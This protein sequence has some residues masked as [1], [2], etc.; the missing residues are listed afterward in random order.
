MSDIS[1][2][3]RP[4]LQVIRIRGLF[5]SRLQKERKENKIF[6]DDSKKENSKAYL[7]FVK[8]W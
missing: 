7:A 4:I 1:I 8:I 3:L 6:D 2:Y 5:V